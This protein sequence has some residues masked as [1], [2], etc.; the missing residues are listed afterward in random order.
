MNTPDRDPGH[1]DTSELRDELPDDLDHA[2][3]VGAYQFPDNSRRRIPGYLYVTLAVICL[4]LWA[5]QR[6]DSAL[7]NDGF[8]WAAAALGWPLLVGALCIAAWYAAVYGFAI[9]EYQLPLPHRI[10]EEGMREGP[11]LWAGLLQS[12]YACVL[13][14]AA[15]VLGGVV[16]SVLL[17][18]SN[19]A[20]R[21]IYPYLL[22]L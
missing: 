22:V 7:V 11:T 5:T 2:N 1:D 9:P 3:F 20:Y 8:A 21:G 10:V 14:F 15:S 13:G 19:I 4:V 6:D 16:L 18:F 12:A 17:S